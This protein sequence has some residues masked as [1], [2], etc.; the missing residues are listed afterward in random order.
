LPSHKRAVSPP[1]IQVTIQD[2]MDALEKVGGKDKLQ[3]VKEENDE[4]LAR[5][6]H[7]WAFNFDNSLALKLGYKP[8]SSFEQA[9]REY[10]EWL[11]EDKAQG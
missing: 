5:I 9:V 3:F 1:G 10:V 6:L 11:A 2:M 7:S 8:D 4:A